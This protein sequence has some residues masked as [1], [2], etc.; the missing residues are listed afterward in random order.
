MVYF[1]GIGAGSRRAAAPPPPGDILASPGRLLPPPE[2]YAQIQGR[3][4]F[5]ENTSFQDKTLLIRRKPFCFWR[6]LLFGTKNALIPAKTFISRFRVW[7]S[8]SCPPC[9][10]IVPA[11]LYQRCAGAGYRSRLR[12]E[13]AFF[14]RSRSRARSEYFLL[15]QKQER[16]LAVFLRF[17]CIFAVYINYYT[18]VKQEQELINFI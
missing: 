7:R 5:L 10:K 9:P 11:P 17:R 4:F 2:K 15:Q 8:R 18:E 16:F 6:T 1:R 12:Q 3:S 13:L 14:N